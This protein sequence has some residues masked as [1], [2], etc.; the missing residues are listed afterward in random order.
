MLLP[1]L[2][3]YKR[4]RK[5]N[6]FFLGRKAMTTKIKPHNLTTNTMLLDLVEVNNESTNL[7]H[8]ATG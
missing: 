2:Y 4:S 6:F 7:A 1:H 5:C 8:H 3:N